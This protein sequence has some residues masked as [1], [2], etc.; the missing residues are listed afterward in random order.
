NGHFIPSGVVVT[1]TSCDGPSAQQRWRVRKGLRGCSSVRFPLG[2]F[3]GAAY[4]RTIVSRP[5]AVPAP[6]AGEQGSDIAEGFMKVFVTGAT[7]YIGSAVALRLKKA[8]HDVLG[9]VR[10]KERGGKLPAAGARLRA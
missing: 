10:R 4:T 6:S 3:R 9:L 1:P 7:G 5:G 8:G 2:D